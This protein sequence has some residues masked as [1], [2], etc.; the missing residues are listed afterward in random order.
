MELS[1]SKVI[2]SVYCLHYR[3]SKR[4]RKLKRG[5]INYVSIPIFRVASSL[6]SYKWFLTEKNSL[7]PWELNFFGDCTVPFS[8]TLNRHLL[9]KQWF[10]VEVGNEI[11]MYFLLSL[12]S[13]FHRFFIDFKPL[14]VPFDSSRICF[15][16]MHQS[17]TM[18][19][20]QKQ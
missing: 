10:Q 4:N 18:G 12:I 8:Y 14:F 5:V 2:S 7:S 11:V 15:N 19:R 6:I 17:E 13:I 1:L 16:A 3:G 9:A 20:L